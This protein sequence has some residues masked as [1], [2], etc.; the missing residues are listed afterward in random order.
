MNFIFKDFKIKKKKSVKKKI[1]NIFENLIKEDSQLIKSLQN[2]YKDSFNKSI[3]TKFK[4]IK[5]ICLIGM[6]GSILGAKA[7]YNFLKKKEKKFF[8]L[9]NL[10]NKLLKK[11]KFLFLII[12]KSGNTLETIVNFNLIFKKKNYKKP[13]FLTENKNNYLIDLASKLKAEVVH[14]NNFIGGR[15]SVMSEVGMLPAGLMGHDP[16]KFRKFND[17]IKDKNFKN[18]LFNSVDNIIEMKR[19]NKTNSIILNYDEDADDL[20]RWYQQLV[21]ESLGKKNKGFLP[22]ISTMPKDNHSLMQHYLDGTR[23]CFFTLFFSK[24]K[25]KKISDKNDYLRNYNHINN[26]SSNDI[27]YAQ[28][29]ATQKVFKNR[30]LPFRSFVVNKKNED[31]LGELFTFFILETILIGKVLNINPFDQPEVELIKVQTNNILKKT[32]FQKL[33]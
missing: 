19:K 10:N 32:N 24:E 18:A 3:L 23:N 25:T 21:A 5:K 14:H 2:S 6:G 28:F 16:K 13:I 17:L 22:L 20:F 12:S 4:K 26:K 31:T 27:A 29:L 11:E 9:D 8:F 1:L 7:I 15:Y 30:H 33:F